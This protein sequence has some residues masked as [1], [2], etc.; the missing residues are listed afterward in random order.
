[1]RVVTVAGREGQELKDFKARVNYIASLIPTL[2]TLNL[3]SKK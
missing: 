1:M 3:T 2:A